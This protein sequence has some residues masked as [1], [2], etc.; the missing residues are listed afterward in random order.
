MGIRGVNFL[1]KL[2]NEQPLLGIMSNMSTSDWKQWAKERPSWVQEDIEEA[3]WRFVD[4]K[5][6]DSLHGA[7]DNRRQ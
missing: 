5:W 4:K 2:I 6:K 1:R 7:G 3:F